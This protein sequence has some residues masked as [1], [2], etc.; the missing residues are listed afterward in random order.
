MRQSSPLNTSQSRIQA[1][2]KNSSCDLDYV[3]NNHTKFGPNRK[4]A[5]KK[6]NFQ[7]QMFDTTD[8]IEVKVIQSSLID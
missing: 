6:Y 7:F 2:V 5:T 3:L 1:K 8:I 4:K